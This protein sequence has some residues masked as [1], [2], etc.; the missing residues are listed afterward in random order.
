MISR[1]WHGYATLNNAEEYEQIFKEE[2]IE[3]IQEKAITGFKGVELLK[4]PFG[5]EME[6]MTIMRFNDIESV[7]AFAGE[8][9]ETAFVPSKVQEILTRFDS[10]VAH[11]ETVEC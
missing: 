1:I 3:I 10:Q 9:Y 11:Y 2:V 5:K 6:F 7:K 4:R 8:D